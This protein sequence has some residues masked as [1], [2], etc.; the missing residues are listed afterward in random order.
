MASDTKNWYIAAK[1][2]KVGPVSEENLKAFYEQKKITGNTKITR[3]GMKEWVSLSASGVLDYDL[4]SDGLPPLPQED[5]PAKVK[6]SANK[7]TPGFIAAATGVAA[8]VIAVMF[9]IFSH[10]SNNPAAAPT[11]S[12]ITQN[13]N[14]ENPSAASIADETDEPIPEE[15]GVLE[16]LTFR[17]PYS[18][19]VFDYPAQFAY[20]RNDGLDSNESIRYWFE[21]PDWSSDDG[22]PY[23]FFAFDRPLI[24]DI[25]RGF[26]P[27]DSV[28][29]SLTTIDIESFIASAADVAESF[30]ASFELLDTFESARDSGFFYLSNSD[31]VS[32]IAANYRNYA[33]LDSS[34]NVRIITMY[35]GIPVGYVDDHQE[36]FNRIIYSIRYADGN[37]S[38]SLTANEAR[39][40]LQVWVDSHPFHLGSE[41]EPEYEEHIF[42]GEEYYGFR[43]GMVRIGIAVV[44]VNKYTGEL[45][46]LSSPGWNEFEPLDDWYF[47]EH[48]PNGGVPDS[49]GQSVQQPAE[50]PPRQSDYGDYQQI[51]DRILDLYL[52]EQ[53]GTT[54]RFGFFNRAEIS[55]LFFEVA[56]ITSNAEYFNTGVGEA[57]MALSSAMSWSYEWQTTYNAQE[58]RNFLALIPGEARERLY[59]NEIFTV[60]PEWV[61][62]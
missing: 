15:N 2:K 43:I 56:A 26:V 25:N 60:F 47:R 24:Y 62:D 30:G 6:N 58:V 16:F 32:R 52:R 41:L 20:E 35:L 51:M 11:D 45:F 57:H 42:D 21:E 3:V 28:E 37:E 9:F 53:G 14:T 44:L 38:D 46:H 7:A 61:I 8:V 4:D 13:G 1:G 55:I 22:G 12:G 40:F 34:G 48:A 19:I 18:D 49:S 59:L 10:M 23:I 31:R 27:T 29:D 36:F 33:F 39:V 50:Q 17:V 5:K 54:S